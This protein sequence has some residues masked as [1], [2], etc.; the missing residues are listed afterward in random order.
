PS[1]VR[2]PK[3][4][5][6]DVARANFGDQQLF[7]LTLE[8]ANPNDASL[9]YTGY[10]A[11]S[12]DPP[13]AAEHTVPLRHIELKRDGKWQ[14]DPRGYCGFG[15]ADLELTAKG[16][17]TFAVTLP[18]D[19]WQAVKVA[20]GHYPG[21]SNEE[22]ST[23]TTW[24]TEITRD[25]IEMAAGKFLSQT[26]PERNLPVG[27]WTIAFANG[28]VES[29]EICKDGTASVSEPQRSSTGKAKLQEGGLLLVFNDDR[30]ERWTAIGKRFVVEHWFPAAQFP[31][32][33]PVLG[34]AERC[35]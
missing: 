3:I 14:P 32:V 17:A 33:A 19:D 11:D 15:L 10:T 23:T 21:W 6:V 18:A 12:F 30:T 7:S 25:A 9:V 4:T 34:I 20:I 16:S 27:R 26:A 31:S 28:V 2:P 1:R 29:G 22:V 8:V 35:D 24:S 13:L 5:L